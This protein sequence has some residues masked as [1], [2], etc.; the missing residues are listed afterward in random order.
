MCA[1][2]ISGNVYDLPAHTVTSTCLGLLSFKLSGQVR[3]SSKQ[4][5]SLKM[6]FH[7]TL[8]SC[9]KLRAQT[10]L[11]LW[12]TVG[13]QYGTAGIPAGLATEVIGGSP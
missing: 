1:C 13:R 2:V 8:K 7:F 6:T 9:F 5:T 11:V 4:S 10:I 3:K 12:K